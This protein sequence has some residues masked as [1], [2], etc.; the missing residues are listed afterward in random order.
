MQYI[1]RSLERKL[2]EEN[3]IIHPLEIKK[4][5]TICYDYITMKGSECHSG[6]TATDHYSG[7]V[8]SSSGRQKS[9]GF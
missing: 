8:R 1:K 4:S 5:A 7:A 3:G 2:V 9:G 6:I